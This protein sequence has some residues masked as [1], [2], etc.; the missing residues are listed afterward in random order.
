MTWDSAVSRPLIVQ[1]TRAQDEFAGD[2]ERF[3]KIYSS[4]RFHRFEG[5]VVVAPERNVQQRQQRP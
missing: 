2:G 3:A 5:N 4:P 1:T